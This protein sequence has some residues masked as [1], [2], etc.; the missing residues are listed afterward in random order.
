MNFVVRKCVNGARH[1]RNPIWTFVG[2]LA[3]VFIT[4][5]FAAPWAHADGVAPLPGFDGFET[6]DD[7]TSSVDL[8][9][10]GLGT[11]PLEGVELGNGAGNAD[12]V[13]ARKQSGP[14]D[15][16]TSII[17]I[18]LVA[19]HL[20]SIDPVDLSPLGGP[21]VGVF[22]DL[23][24]TLDASDKFFTG[25]TPVPDGTGLGP[26]VFNL[27][28]PDAP[29]PTSIG[30][31]RI[32]HD[33]PVKTFSACFGEIAPCLAESACA[34]PPGVAGG[35]VFADAIFTVM[36]GDPADPGDVLLSAPAPNILLASLGNW[37]HVEPGGMFPSGGFSVTDIDHCGP[38]VPISVP[39]AVELGSFTATT[40]PRVVTLSWETESELNNEGFYV[41]RSTSPSR[42]FAVVNATLIL[43][44]GGPA[45]GAA[46]QFVDDTAEPGVTYYYKLRDLGTSGVSTLHGAD[47]CTF[48]SDPDCQL[49]VVTV[50]GRSAVD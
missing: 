47:A 19:L 33:N 50:P 28:V 2:V 38:H 40:I 30:R 4:V 10:F 11:V 22:S 23:H 15:G 18:E 25:T 36:G 43:A 1:R 29:L 39:L 7:G 13:V 27:P 14:G 34:M 35:G 6:P 37:D 45:F 12:T 17:D 5:A 16:V 9:G 24:I 42:G 48:G 8:S 26:S 46:Y 32:A 3:A 41:L 49:L 21:F 20:Q 31:M 44:E